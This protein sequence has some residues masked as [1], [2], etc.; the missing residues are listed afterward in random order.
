MDNS[1][2]LSYFWNLSDKNTNDSIS[3]ASESIVDSVDVKQ[4]FENDPNKVIT[5]VEKYKLYLQLCHNPSEDI[6]YTFHRI[7]YF[8]LILLDRWYK[9][10]RF[11]IQKR[12]FINF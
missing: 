2:F 7:V 9:F 11:R 5:K 3:T 10:Y 8:Y 12:I 4:K 6:L 1:D